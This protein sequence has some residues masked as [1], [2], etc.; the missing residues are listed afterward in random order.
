MGVELGPQSL[1]QLPSL[2]VGPFLDADQDMGRPHLFRSGVV[3]PV[4]Q[5]GLL[6]NLLQ[7]R[8][9]GLVD[10]LLD[11]A[12]GEQFLALEPQAADHRGVPVHALSFRFLGQCPLQQDLFCDPEQGVLVGL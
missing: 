11:A 4:G 7:I 12:P 9:L 1:R 10:Q 8:E 2:L 3:V 5:I 6:G